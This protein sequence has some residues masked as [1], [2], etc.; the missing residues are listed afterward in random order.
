MWEDNPPYFDSKQEWIL[1]KSLMLSTRFAENS[2][3]AEKQESVASLKILSKRVTELEQY[4]D[5][6]KSEKEEEISG[7]KV[8]INDLQS[9]RIDIV[10]KC[11]IFEEQ[12][13]SLD[14][15]KQR[16]ETKYTDKINEIQDE[17]DQEIRSLRS[18]CDQLSEQLREKELEE[19]DVQNEIT[20][21]NSDG[22]VRQV[23]KLSKNC[24]SELI[25]LN[26]L[27]EQ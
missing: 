27:L 2:A 13:K 7:L 6:I 24:N 22:S 18:H 8:K 26:A 9:E 10:T 3:S 16:I 14:I 12:A 23:W 19:Q 21:Y 4:S 1:E 15:E 25:K 20:T 5:F 17:Y 11:S